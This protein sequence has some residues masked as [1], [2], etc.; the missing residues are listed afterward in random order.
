M[1]RKSKDKKC[2]ELINN[3]GAVVS[4]AVRGAVRSLFLSHLLSSK[5][6]TYLHSF[7]LF[8]YEVKLNIFLPYSWTI[9]SCS[10]FL[11]LLVAFPGQEQSFFSF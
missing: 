1:R 7:N 5:S 2:Y 10:A 9:Y 11:G 8:P 3:G 4:G 6:E